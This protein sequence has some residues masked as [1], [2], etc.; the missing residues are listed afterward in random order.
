M[1]ES[2]SAGLTYC[3]PTLICV[4]PGH[5]QV[6]Q[7]SLFQSL[8]PSFLLHLS[9]VVSCNYCLAGR[10]ATLDLFRC[11]EKQN[12]I[13]RRNLYVPIEHSLR[14]SRSVLEMPWMQPLH[15]LG[16][17]THLALVLRSRTFCLAC[18]SFFAF[19]RCCISDRGT[20]FEIGGTSNLF[21]VLV[22]CAHPGTPAL[23]ATT[24]SKVQQPFG[25][26]HN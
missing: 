6:M 1:V 9:K 26:A 20:E 18:I 17:R 15:K 8:G 19:L 11:S 25:P 2:D 13:C 12:C 3:W 10:A 14:L 16:F 23:E 21:A 5:H 22:N 4:R 24:F 7:P